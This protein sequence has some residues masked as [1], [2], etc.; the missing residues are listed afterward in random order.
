M[1]QLAKELGLV[2]RGNRW[3]YRRRVPED[4][5]PTFGGRREIKESLRTEVYS[6]A[7]AL[8]NEVAV[9]WDRLFADRRRQLTA[10]NISSAIH[11]YVSEKSRSNEI[12]TRKSQ[13]ATDCRDDALVEAQAFAQIY[14][15][16]EHELTRV[17]IASLTKEVFS[18]LLPKS[19][20]GLSAVEQIDAEARIPDILSHLSTSDQI[21]ID[22]LMRQAVLELELRALDV[23][24]GR[25]QVIR[26]QDTF[27]A[28]GRAPVTLEKAT[29][30]YLREHFASKTVNLKREKSLR[31]EAAMMLHVLGRKVLVSQI[32]RNLCREF[33]DTI[34]SL[35]SNITKH[36][37][38]YEN[39]DLKSLVSEATRKSLPRMKRATQSKYITM[40]KSVL[41]SAVVEGHL[42]TNPAQDLK[43]RG[44]KTP[45]KQARNAFDA[46][47]LNRIFHTAPYT[48]SSERRS[49][50]YWAALVG[51]F[52]G[53]RQNEICQMDIGDIRRSP[54]GVWYI[55]VNDDGED[56]SVKNERSRRAI[57]IHSEL[58]KLG[59]VAF[60]SDEQE[61]RETGKLFEEVRRAPDRNY[62]YLLSRWFNQTFLKHAQAKTSKKSFHSLRHSFRD[63][64]RRARTP[65]DFVD[66]IGGWNSNGRVVT[67][68]NY[69]DGLHL[70]DLA[71]EVEKIS[72][73]GLD[74]SHLYKP[75][76]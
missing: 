1:D 31:A 65:Q 35:P 68:E 70:S 58:I 52:T 57:P 43:P 19:K 40:L 72:Y 42:S 53:M 6:E 21:E 74:L 51:L 18:S 49:A 20:P 12:K 3:I 34:D 22:E 63:A 7:K 75:S 66:Q 11:G 62:G 37:P 14:Q 10:T 41:A 71:Q 32:D 48:P 17:A 13:S 24:Q 8:R 25:P 55:D 39:M 2:R 44:V 29:E 26:H 23:L 61:R 16:P 5:V 45:P 69:G 50:R 56:K 36:F 27:L 33:R 9:K 15:N 47:D 59:F 38:D 54:D 67:S 46:E 30:D 4:L 76:I 28:P 64:L 60:A 73:P